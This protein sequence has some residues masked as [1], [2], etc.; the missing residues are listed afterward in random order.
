MI[1]DIGYALE[2]MDKS[3]HDLVKEIPKV[4]AENPTLYREMSKKVYKRDSDFV[5][6]AS[7]NIMDMYIG[8]PPH[9]HTKGM[10]GT[11]IIKD[12][13][14]DIKDYIYRSLCSYSIAGEVLG[15]SNITKELHDYRNKVKLTI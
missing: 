1:L 9:F 15:D 8:N 12:Y 14:S 5:H 2:L 13:A 3:F 4:S 10:L 6:G 7:P 11:P